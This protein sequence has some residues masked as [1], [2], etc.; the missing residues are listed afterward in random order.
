MLDYILN[1][2]HDFFVLIKFFF[3]FLLQTNIGNK[4]LREED[5]KL[6]NRTRSF[7]FTSKRKCQERASSDRD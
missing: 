4:L 3:K 6:V 1:K 7:N 2:E 5:T